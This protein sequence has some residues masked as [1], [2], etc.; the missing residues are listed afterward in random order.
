[1]TLLVVGHGAVELLA[2]DHVAHSA[3]AACV[4]L[5][6][7]LVGIGFAPPPRGWLGQT[8]PNVGLSCRPL[9][10]RPVD[11]RA[12]ASPAVLQRFLT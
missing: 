11:G 9:V 3:L 8:E 12:R 7:L 6:T 5:F 4:L 10:I 1:L 2:H